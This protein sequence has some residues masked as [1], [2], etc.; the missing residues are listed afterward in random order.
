LNEGAAWDKIMEEVWDEGSELPGYLANRRMTLAG[1]IH[2][3]TTVTSLDDLTD[4]YS[5]QIADKRINREFFPD[6]EG[7]RRTI[8]NAGVDEG[9][10]FTLLDKAEKSQ[11]NLAQLIKSRYGEELPASSSIEEAKVNV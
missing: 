6:F 7:I 3:L 9:T 1:K 2:S 11:I 10:L 8:V 4:T 5:L